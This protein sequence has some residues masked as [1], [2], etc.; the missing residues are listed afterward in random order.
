MV[1]NT[2]VEEGEFDVTKVE[3]SKWVSKMMNS[4]CKMVDFP[5]VKH[6]AQC[7]TLFC[8]LEQECLKVANDGGNRR[9]IKVGQKGLRELQSLLSIVNYEGLSLG[10]EFRDAVPQAMSRI[11][12]T[13]VS[14]DWVDHFGNVSQRVLPCKLKAHKED[15][16]KWNSEEFGDLA[17]RKK[18]LLS[19]LM[20]LVKDIFYDG[21]NITRFFRRLG[22]SHRRTNN[23]RSIKVDGVLYEDGSAVQSQVIQFYQNLYT[24][25][26]MWHPIVDGLDFVCIGEGERLSLER[27]FS[28]EEP[29]SLVGSVY[30]LLSKVLANKLRLVLD[31]LI[32]ESQNSFVGRRQIL[33]SVYI[34][35]KCLDSKLKSHVLGVVC[36]L[37]IE[38]AYDHVNWDAL[39]YLLGRMGFGMK[40]RGW[41]KACITIV[42]FSI[43]V[44][45]SPVDFFRSSRG[46][47]QG[48]LLSPLLFLLIMEVLSQI[49]KK[50]KDC[51]L[52]R[53]FHV[54]PI[55]FIGVCISHLLFA[56]NT[57][58]FC[59]A[60]R[61]Q[62]LSIWLVLTY[63]HAFTSLK[64]NVGHS[65]IV[66]VGEVENIGALATILRCRVG[67]LPNEILGIAV[68]SLAVGAYASVLW[69]P[70]GYARFY[71]KLCV[72]L[73]LLAGKI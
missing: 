72:V 18:C 42:H 61:D 68:G 41:I 10:I 16:K 48:D 52:L 37:D 11:E 33:D 17:F 58:L 3:H 30:K 43:L 34:A 57:I 56:D 19:K 46:F 28:K 12:R 66:S 32:P 54:G 15:L 64:V 60:P 51:G 25:T 35:N 2:V 40:W 69:D 63:F 6:E 14:V 27:E 29:I 26:S 71:G 5:I 1:L 31:I 47:R 65:E 44:N 23:I 73:E 38:K 62:L 4:F 70:I 9:L 36:K 24:E 22:N 20:G 59:D 21:D 67:S 53:G 55:T 50:T 45:G 8:L 39:F 7:G 49:L 13:L